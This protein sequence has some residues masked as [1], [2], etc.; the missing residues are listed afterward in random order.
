MINDWVAG[1]IAYRERRVTQFALHSLSD[2]ELKDFGA[3]R[4]S[5]GSASHRCRDVNV[6]TRR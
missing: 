3:C 2:I 1:A 4:R 6:T 5:P